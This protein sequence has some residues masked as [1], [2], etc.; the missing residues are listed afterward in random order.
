MLIQ[1]G[2]GSGVIEKEKPEYPAFTA[3]EIEALLQ[4]FQCNGLEL[5]PFLKKFE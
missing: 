4:Y 1:N 3:K 5:K 2:M